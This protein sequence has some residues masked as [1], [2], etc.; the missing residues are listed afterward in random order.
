MSQPQPEAPDSLIVR[1]TGDWWN[2]E[3]R[4]W[5]AYCGGAL[6][7]GTSA[8]GKQRSTRDHVVS[9]Q[10]K[11]RHITIPACQPCN[12]AKSNLGMPEF[13]LTPYFGKVRARTA[14]H[15]WALRDLWLV[16]ALAAVHQARDAS[17]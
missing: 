7:K 16:V 4:H 17:G 14:P 8:A 5:C 9:R 1:R 2:D 11:G 3:R 10:H 13:M 15:R 6:T 12:T